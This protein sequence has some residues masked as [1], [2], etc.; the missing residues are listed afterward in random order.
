MKIIRKNNVT[1]DTKITENK[2][3]N[4]LNPLSLDMLEDSNMKISAEDEGIRIY[5]KKNARI[6]LPDTFIKYSDIVDVDDNTNSVQFTVLPSRDFSQKFKTLRFGLF[7]KIFGLSP[8]RME[9]NKKIIKNIQNN[10]QENRDIDIQYSVLLGDS[11]YFFTQ[12]GIIFSKWG[13]LSKSSFLLYGDYVPYSHFFYVSHSEPDQTKKL[14]YKGNLIFYYEKSLYKSPRWRNCGG[15]YLPIDKDEIKK[16]Y[17]FTLDKI[18]KATDLPYEAVKFD[19]YTV[20]SK[21]N[22]SGGYAD[23]LQPEIWMDI[24]IDKDKISVLKDSF[25]SSKPL[26]S[27]PFSKVVRIRAGEKDQLNQRVTATRI[28]ILGPYAMA[29]PKNESSSYQFVSIDIID[30]FGN[31]QPILFS[32]DYIRDFYQKVYR[33]FELYKL[34]SSSIPNQCQNNKETPPMNYIEE[35][36]Q[37]KELLDLGIISKEEFEMKKKQILNI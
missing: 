11:K 34:A 16:I 13:S 28:A 2:T 22:Y 19:I 37:L 18:S 10:V 36:K 6:K 7:F 12:D 33:A 32:G 21:M 15:S 35:L 4:V 30:S 29:V 20:I 1:Y 14:S 5:L 25:K 3:E 24:V 17:E 9:F 23:H 26:F 31:E 8:E 27:I